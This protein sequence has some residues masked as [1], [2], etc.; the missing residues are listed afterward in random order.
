MREVFIK[1]R[2]KRDVLGQNR[3]TISITGQRFPNVDI[4]P[5]KRHAGLLVIKSAACL[6]N[7][8][9]H[10]IR[11]QLSNGTRFTRVLVEISPW[12]ERVRRCIDIT[13]R[14]GNIVLAGAK[15]PC[16]PHSYK[17]IEHKAEFSFLPAHCYHLRKSEK[18]LYRSSP[19]NRNMSTMLR[20]IYIFCL[21]IFFGFLFGQW[22]WYGWSGCSSD[23]DC[24]AGVSCVPTFGDIGVCGW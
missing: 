17:Y 18:V 16:R 15:S 22:D 2:W 24:A 5:W 11:T 6:W 4:T 13:W 8:A 19:S 10:A 14:L 12:T 9:S 23:D 7:A 1:E 21:S 3:I 20:T